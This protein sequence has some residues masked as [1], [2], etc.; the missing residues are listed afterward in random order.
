MLLRIILVVICFRWDAASYGRGGVVESLAVVTMPTDPLP[1]LDPHRSSSSRLREA[2][3]NLSAQAGC[4]FNHWSACGFHAFQGWSFERSAKQL[5]EQMRRAAE[6]ATNAA[7]RT[8]AAVV[9]AN[10]SQVR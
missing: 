5:A 10:G 1:P 8:A 7:E 9:Q 4:D 2:Y 6:V 3:A